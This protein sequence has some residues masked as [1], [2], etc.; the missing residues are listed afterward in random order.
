M[1]LSQIELNRF[2]EENELSD[3]IIC[4]HSAF[5]SIGGYEGD[6][7]EFCETF[8][9]RGCTLMVPSHSWDFVE[10][11]PLNKTPTVQSKWDYEQIN[12][13]GYTPDSK[14][15]DSD[16]GI[17]T[18]YLLNHPDHV[19]SNNPLGSFT[20]VGPYAEELLKQTHSYHTQFERLTRLNGIILLLGLDCSKMSYIHYVKE[21]CGISMVYRWIKGGEGREKWV[22]GGGCS[23]NFGMLSPVLEPITQFKQLGDAEVQLFKA[24]DVFNTLK[25]YFRKNGDTTR[26][27]EF[28]DSC[29]EL[30]EI[31]VIDED[32]YYQVQGQDTFWELGLKFGVP[33]KHIMSLC[34]DFLDNGQWLL[35]ED[36][37]NTEGYYKVQDEETVESL[38]AKFSLTEEQ[39][40]SQCDGNVYTGLWIS[41]V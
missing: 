33:H 19:R 17:I 9:E 22:F 4:L 31:K 30:E 38:M 39:I 36:L 23:K 5:S 10:D 40:T 41:V 6:I 21:M 12:S 3:R 14:E 20:A 37:Y 11:S 35:L 26:C 18:T 34:N 24:Q 32:D 27:K 25:P 28:C 8:L 13:S 1:P 16:K 15:V 7:S 29:S 2:I